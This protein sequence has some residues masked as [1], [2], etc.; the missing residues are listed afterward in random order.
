[1]RFPCL[2]AAYYPE[3]WD[4]SEIEIDILKMQQQGISLVRIGEFAWHRME[5]S[6]GEYDFSFFQ[7][8][9]D[10]LK[11]A[12]IS[13][14]LS[15]PTATPPTWLTALCPDMLVEMENGHRMQHGGRRHCCSNH[16]VYNK[17]S[18]RIVEQMAKAFA[19]QPNVIGWQID[20]EIYTGDGGCFCPEC[21]LRFRETLRSK[22]GTIDC[23]NKAWN[24]NLFSQWYDSFE[25]I[26]APRNA[27]HNPHLKQQ[28]MTF[29][30]DSHI[31]FVHKQ[32][33]VLHSFVNVPIGT[34]T[35]PVAAMDYRRMTAP[36]DVV[37]FNHYNT[38]DD[39]WKTGFWFD[40]L[41]TLKQRPFWNMETATCWNGS[42]RIEQS[43]K[44]DGFCRAN[45]WLPIALGGEAN[46]YWLWR[47]HW[48]G[49]ELMHGAVLS[50]CGRP[51]HI[52]NEV[53]QVAHEYVKAADFLN[54]TSVLPNC[55]LHFSSLCHNMQATQPIVQNL[56]Y[57]TALESL[58]YHPMVDMG[59]C[60]DVI[61]AAQPLEGYRLIVTPLMMTLEEEDLG[62]RLSQWVR[63]GGCW[64]VGPLSDVRTMD[65][66]RYM[67]RPFGMLEEFTGTRWVYSV[68]DSQALVQCAWQDGTAF[69]GTG[70][71]EL[72][73]AQ[74]SLATVTEGHIALH[75]KSV[76]FQ[77]RVG[78]GCVI[79]LGTLPSKNTWTKLLQLAC[80]ETGIKPIQ[81]EGSL[82]VVPRKGE[83]AEG[84]IAVETAGKPASI[85]L[86][87]PM[88]E[89]LTECV[90]TG[91]Q[92]VQPYQTMVLSRETKQQS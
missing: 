79:V 84:I 64:V 17:Y 10:Q 5:P 92:K 72:F 45:S 80:Q 13:V 62:T 40:H 18:L 37:Q 60:P 54:N 12:N 47:T 67:D 30:N 81:M 32:A 9:V 85:V 39:L 57:T 34:D 90:L 41:R 27:W 19:N 86:E 44:P 21:Q 76:A 83:K 7:H 42:T 50:A 55:A 33:E 36:L 66:T 82:V 43:I 74:N 6:Q 46:L 24:Q 35:M 91:K 88:L 59:L 77:C 8:V 63:D 70:W 1:M 26:S 49:H 73:D 53:K 69:E 2:G 23:L 15:T 25:Q 38:C 29:Q 11:E 31:A 68:P 87:E 16:P 28:W 22:F 52:A 89:L 20:N 4:E 3:A 58:F 48:A 78:K 56:E 65:G 14:I 61:D 51:M 75:G 71:Y